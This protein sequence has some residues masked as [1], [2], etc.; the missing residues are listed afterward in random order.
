MKTTVQFSISI[1]Y[2][3]RLISTERKN[4]IHSYYCLCIGTCIDLILLCFCFFIFLLYLYTLNIPFTHIYLRIF[5]VSTLH[6]VLLLLGNDIEIVI[7]TKY[8]NFYLQSHMQS[9]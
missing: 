7:V 3:E 2:I 1:V 6:V 9:K 4:T 5:K 8:S